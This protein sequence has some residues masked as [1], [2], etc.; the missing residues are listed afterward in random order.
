MLYFGAPKTDSSTLLIDMQQIVSVSRTLIF[1]EVNMVSK[2]MK[3]FGSNIWCKA[4]LNHHSRSTN[5]TF[6]SREIAHVFSDAVFEV[7]VDV[8]K[9]L[10]LIKGNGK[11]R[12]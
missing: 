9:Y 2:V 8:T 7:V 10:V 4:D 12:D 6:R 11:R 3:L 5:L 1:G